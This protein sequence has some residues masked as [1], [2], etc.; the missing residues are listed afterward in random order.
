MITILIKYYY[1]NT[2]WFF[3]IVDVAW[4][5][6]GTGHNYNSNAGFGRMVGGQTE[7]DLMSHICCQQCRVC[8]H[9]QS[10]MMPVRKHNCVANYTGSS[11]SMEYE[12]IL[13][14]VQKAPS[15]RFVVGLLV[16]DDDSVMRA[17]L[18]HAKDHQD[19]KLPE[20]FLTPE[21]LAN[22]RHQ[23]K[24]VAEHF[25][26]LA[27]AP[28]QTSR[29]NKNHAKRLKKDW[30]YM[31]RKIGRPICQ[32]SKRQPVLCSSTYITITRIVVLG[33]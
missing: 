16:S 20:W 10:K 30:G 4:P 23:I 6:K 14:L 24:V 17:H 18:H 25:Y 2:V 19:G 5:T 29:V 9:A 21:F 31:I 12:I 26:A 15:C 11:K 13:L 8:K 27:A 28:V 3:N 7:K 22:P 33:A 1:T 32:P